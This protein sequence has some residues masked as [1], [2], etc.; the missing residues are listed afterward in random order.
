[1]PAALLEAG[2]PHIVLETESQ[3]GGIFNTLLSTHLC[4]HMPRYICLPFS[5]F[6]F[7]RLFSA[8]RQRSLL[9]RAAMP[10]QLGW[11]IW[12]Q[13]IIGYVA[14]PPPPLSSPDPVGAPSRRKI[15]DGDMM[16]ML[17]FEI[18][19]KIIIMKELWCFLWSYYFYDYYY[20]FI[21]FY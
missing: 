6:C 1:M 17:L 4:F 13:F 16:V 14:P 3:A 15:G 11:A 18:I 21:C 20:Y 5:F 8:F 9:E 10:C 12:L 7:S 19:I 2:E